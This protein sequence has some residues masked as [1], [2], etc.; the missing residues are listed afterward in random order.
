M[1][2]RSQETVRE[3]AGKGVGGSE[4]CVQH[5]CIRPIITTE[6]FSKMKIICLFQ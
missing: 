4:R 3:T 6:N 2:Q 1:A 5:F